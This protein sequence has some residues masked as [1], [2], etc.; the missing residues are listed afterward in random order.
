M[1]A[2]DFLN[3]GTDLAES[4]P[5]DM[6]AES[7]LDMPVEAVESAEAFLDTSKLADPLSDIPEPIKEIPSFRQGVAPGVLER[8]KRAVTDLFQREPGV[9]PLTKEDYAAFEPADITRPEKTTPGYTGTWAKEYDVVG[10]IKDIGKLFYDIPI[11][12]MGAMASMWEDDNPEAEYDWK[13]I[14]RKAQTVRGEQRAAEAGG[15]KYI[16]PWVQRKDIREASASAGFSGVAMGAGL[17]GGVAASPIPIPGARVAGALAGS[18]VAAYKMDKA[19]FTQQLIDSYRQAVSED[20]NR[21]VTSD[22]V[23]ALVEKTKGLRGKHALWEAI[24]E[25]VGNV[26]QLSG[27][28]A[29]F[30]SVLG[31][32]LGLRIFKIIAGMYGAEVGTETITQTG[33]HNVEI[34]AGLS[35]G[36]KRS[37]AS[38][39]DMYESF[40]E[41]APQTFVLVSLTGGAGAVGTKTYQ[42]IANPKNN[43]DASE[44]NPIVEKFNKGEIELSQAVEQINNSNVSKET[45][46]S[47]INLLKEI[48]VT[49]EESKPTPDTSHLSETQ[50]T[51]AKEV[52]L[53]EITRQPEIG[54]A[55]TTEELTRKRAKPFEEVPREPA[56]VSAEAFEREITEEERVRAAAEIEPDI[57]K[58]LRRAKEIPVTPEQKDILQGMT[59]EKAQDVAIQWNEI[60][61]TGTEVEKQARITEAETLV[62][63]RPDLFNLVHGK[64]AV[65]PTPTKPKAEVAPEPV[66]VEKVPDDADYLGR[67]ADGKYVYQDKNRVL[68][69]LET[70]RVEGELPI[71]QLRGEEKPI[72]PVKPATEIP[73]F[74]TTGEAEAFGEKATLEQITELK[75]L[76]KESEAKYYTLAGEGKQAEADKEALKAQLYRE[77]YEA[78]EKPVP[79]KG[80]VKIEKKKLHEMTLAEVHKEPDVLMSSEL[81]QLHDHKARTLGFEK[82]GGSFVEGYLKKLAEVA[83]KTDMPAAMTVYEA[84]SAYKKG[85][86]TQ[87]SLDAEKILG[88]LHKA[89]RETLT[90]DKISE[91]HKKDIQK[92]LKEGESVPESVLIEYPDLKPAKPQPSKPKKAT[93][94]SP[95]TEPIKGKAIPKPAPKVEKPTP[96]KEP[97]KP[98]EPDF[99]KMSLSDITVNIK[100]IREKTG[101]TIVVKENAQKALGEVDSE[102]SILRKIL[103]CL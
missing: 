101:E 14:A 25:A 31:K 1:R 96:Y 28:G 63:E 21:D 72:K 89:E 20:E 47:A 68:Y 56:E 99:S 48:T 83:G 35:A 78:K 23:V 77:A 19:M 45:K 55:L 13:D 97:V 7:F 64:L 34:E 18:G 54:K 33:Q 12:T 103:D 88:K 36:Q 90:P 50:K 24:P 100:A 27:I 73:T 91:I 26:A 46:E 57:N 37:F 9:G 69:K 98:F 44:V 32:N 39:D 40:K 30:K 41:V 53:E 75:R 4:M 38:M 15:E 82:A 29:I 70:P 3:E 79:I 80:K 62:R 102:I 74:K 87:A 58:F 43:V 6:S 49:P 51:I 11:N 85:N 65:K 81:R 76:R 92:A 8:G 42:L 17:A 94:I 95:R 22:E 66:G 71:K 67:N 5:T 10:G 61:E 2:E 52:I 84:L 86:I 16:L 59:K 60:W 93:P